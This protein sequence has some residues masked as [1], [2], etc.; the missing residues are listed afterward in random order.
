MWLLQAAVEPAG[1]S[2]LEWLGLGSGSA[3]MGA[4]IYWLA[5]RMLNKFLTTVE[6]LTTEVKAAS[7][8]VV[9]LTYALELQS[10]LTGKEMTA[11]KEE[12]SATRTEM[13]E[14]FA[15]VEKKLDDGAKQFSKI[16]EELV[17]CRKDI[18]HNKTNIKRNSE[19][20]KDR[21]GDA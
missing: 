5:K 6:G 12:A 16:G 4:L 1:A 20:I 15:K 17:A 2:V 21:S 3:G 10:A 9:K 19:R 18:E 7:D 8:G 11:V 13:R 14:G